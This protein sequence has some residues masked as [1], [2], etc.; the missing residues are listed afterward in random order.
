MKDVVE[1]KVYIL[2]ENC[3]L[4]SMELFVSQDFWFSSRKETEFLLTFCQDVFFWESDVRAYVPCLNVPQ[5][6]RGRG[7]REVEERGRWES[8]RVRERVRVR[9]TVREGE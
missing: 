7:G 1:Q 5:L 9:G 6:C 3:S 8:K 4:L 2:L